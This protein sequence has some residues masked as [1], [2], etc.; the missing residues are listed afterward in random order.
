[1]LFYLCAKIFFVR[2]IDVSLGTIRTIMSV[3]NK[4]FIASVIGFIEVT[5]WFLVVKE[6]LNTDNNSFFIVLSYAGGFSMGTYIGGLLSNRYIKGYMSVQIITENEN[7]LTSILRDNGYGVSAIDIRGRDKQSKALL[8][9]QI[10]NN[11]LD[12]LKKLVN[13]YDRRAFVIINETKNIINGF[14]K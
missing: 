2:I 4:N 14:I 6:A 10:N 12:E 5:V 3:R 9:V 11:K 13:K 8:M 1:M 7:K